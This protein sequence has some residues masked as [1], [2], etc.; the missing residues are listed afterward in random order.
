VIVVGRLGEPGSLSC[1]GAPPPSRSD[2]TSTDRLTG[3]GGKAPKQAVAAVS[4]R[5][6]WA[7]RHARRGRAPTCSPSSATRAPT[8]PPCRLAT[9]LRTGLA[10]GA[11]STPRARNMITLSAPRA[12][13]ALTPADLPISQRTSPASAGGPGRCRR[14]RR[15]A[16]GMPSARRCAQSGALPGR[17]APPSWN[18]ST[19]S[20]HAGELGQLL[21]MPAPDSARAR[22]AA[23]RPRRSRAVRRGDAR[24]AGAVVAAAATSRSRRRPSRVVDTGRCRRPATCGALA[25]RSA[26]APKSSRPPVGRHA[27]APRRHRA[28]RPVRHARQP[29]Y[30]PCS[31]PTGALT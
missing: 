21:G 24:R 28:V 23:A 13:A 12:T 22:D 31:P 27:G 6:A 4:A 19:C 26:V 1:R 18:T 10:G 11:R 9:E 7:G 3:I 30:V 8:P 15:R 14:R 2:V 25:R 29:P 16:S 20:C 17:C 5:P